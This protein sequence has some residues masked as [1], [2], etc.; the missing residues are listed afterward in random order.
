MKILLILFVVFLTG[1]GTVLTPREKVV[2]INSEKP[3]EIW[4]DGERLVARGKVNSVKVSN[5]ARRGSEYLLVREVDGDGEHRI[6][7]DRKFNRMTLLNL[8]ILF[9]TIGYPV[10]YLTGATGKLRKTTYEV[11]DFTYEDEL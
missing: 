5:R 11:K 4:V 10:D 8:P 6:E 2:N 1:C 7:L 9:G 3:V